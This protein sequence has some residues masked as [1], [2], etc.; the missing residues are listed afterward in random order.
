MLGLGCS[1]T[2]RAHR[3]P[4]NWN[5][6]ARVLPSI[7]TSLFLEFSLSWPEVG[8]LMQLESQV[9]REPVT[10]TLGRCGD[11]VDGKDW[12]VTWLLVCHRAQSTH[13]QGKRENESCEGLRK[14]VNCQ[15]GWWLLRSPSSPVIAGHTPQRQTRDLRVRVAESES[16][17]W[18]HP[19][20][21]GRSGML[22]DVKNTGWGLCSPNPPASP[23]VAEA[24]PPRPAWGTVFYIRSPL[25][26]VPGADASQ[27]VA[28]V[29]ATCSTTVHSLQV[30][31]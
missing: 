8:V 25:M 10:V 21:V 3:W 9:S 15:K 7:V 23:L 14:Q 5:K 12:R 29:C 27:G 19:T 11:H 2:W 24:G 30:Y 31:N 18:S 16:S 1:R 28:G 4:S 26:A 13:R 20:Q 6:R 22:A 17:K